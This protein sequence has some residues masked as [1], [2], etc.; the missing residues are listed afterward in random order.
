MNRYAQTFCNDLLRVRYINRLL[1]KA[2]MLWYLYVAGK[3]SVH[4][5]EEGVL[6][7]DYSKKMLLE[8]RTS[9]RPLKIIGPL[10]QISDVRLDGDTLS[11][12]PRYETELFYL[13]GFGFDMSKLKAVDMIS[14]SPLI[15][16]G[17]MHSLPY[18]ENSFD[19]VIAGWI[20]PYSDN[21]H[22][23][24]SEIVRVCRDGAIVAISM[25]YYT[26]ESLEKI[27]EYKDGPFKEFQENRL[28]RVEQIIELFGENFNFLYFQNDPSKTRPGEDSHT[29]AIFSVKK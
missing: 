15:D 17:N 18:S 5:N 6:G 20:L 29:L 11:I 7:N 16:V 10:S 3:L 22:K 21:F 23:A 28:Q 14:Y 24:V 4:K 1:F 13:K 19:T 27:Y 26:R 25:S 9:D 2:R 8:G 12:G